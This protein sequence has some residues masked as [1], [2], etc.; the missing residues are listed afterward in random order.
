MTRPLVFVDLDDTLFQTRRKC[1]DEEAPHLTQ[2]TTARN[3]NHSFMTRPQRAF[4]EWLLRSADVI[5][6]TARGSDAFKAV[7]LPFRCGAVLANGGVLLTP[8]GTVD[9]EWRALM[10]RELAASAHV[11]HALI[12]SGREAARA[13]GLDL[14]SWLAI[15]DD[16]PIYAVFKDN[17]DPSGAPLAELEKAL[18]PETGWTVHR[19]ANNLAFIPKTVSKAR[20]VAHLIAKARRD[21]PGRPILGFGDSDTD[22]AFLSLCDLWGAPPNSQIAKTL[23]KSL[24]TQRR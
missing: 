24:E 1:P 3:D 15:E 5:P 18:R 16:L 4:I 9:A 12:E 14:R 7:R 21:A 2:A 6:V 23:V 13:L 22:F 20:A 17:A 10:A 8:E 19:N 11:L